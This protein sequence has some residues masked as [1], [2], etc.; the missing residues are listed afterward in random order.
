MKDPEHLFY[1]ILPGD[2]RPRILPP[3]PRMRGQILAL[4]HCEE[5][6]Q[7]AMRDGVH[8]MICDNDAYKKNLQVNELATAYFRRSWPQKFQEHTIKGPA[9]ILPAISIE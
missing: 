1:Y 2:S 3:T 9:L 4:L 6:A 7:E 8:I 5:V